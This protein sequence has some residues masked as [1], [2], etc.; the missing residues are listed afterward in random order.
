MIEDQEIRD[1]FQSDGLEQIQRIEAGILE[2]EQN[3][4][5][6]ELLKSIFR[7]AHSLKGSAGILGLKEI[8]SITHV[9][10]DFLGGMSKGYSDY[11]P[12]YADRICYALDQLRL[13]I[14]QA[15][16]GEPAGVELRK[17]VD[18]LQ[19]KLPIEGRAQ[20][21]AGAV[22]S[23]A[24]APTG[25]E[26]AAAAE[27]AAPEDAGAASAD[28]AGAIVPAVHRDAGAGEVSAAKPAAE[29]RKPAR[30]L[31]MMRVDP[32]RL[33]QLL[34]NTGELIIAKNRIQKR[35][36]EVAR[37]LLELEEFSKVWRRLSGF[38]PGDKQAWDAL[39]RQLASLKVKS[40][41]DAAKLDQVAG[42]LES[43]VHKVRLLP[44]SSA[45]DILPR[46][47]RD[48]SREL[49]KSVYLA[50][51][52]GDV[53]ADK[54][55]I[56]ELKDALMHLVRN[57][58]DHG[59]ETE[60]ERE[61]V[62]K[63]NPAR[64]RV[65]GVQSG[66]FIRI[67][68]EDDGRGLNAR[69]IREI[70][71][72]KQLFSE[73]ELEAMPDAQVFQIIFHNGF[74]TRREVTNLSG[75]GY[76]MDIVRNFADR[77]KGSI[78]IDSAPGAGTKFS[79]KIPTNFSTNQVL[80]AGSNG[81]KYGVPTE[82]V[83]QSLVVRKEAIRFVESRPV[84]Q[85]AG[86]PV[87][88]IR[89]ADFFPVHHVRTEAVKRNHRYETCIVLNYNGDRLALAADYI[90]EKQ[91]I[92]LKPLQGILLSVRKLSGTAILESGEICGVLNL[93]NLYQDVK[94]RAAAAHS[95][96]DDSANRRRERSVL[97]VEDS[98]I[99]RAQIQRIIE[100]EG[101][102]TL[103]ATNGEEAWEKL[104]NQPVSLVLTD[105][106]MPVLDGFEL[107]KR[108]R[109]SESFRELPTVLLTSLGS[110]EHIDKGKRLGAD[111]YL[112]KSQFDQNVLLQTVER[113]LAGA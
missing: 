22:A 82:F 57:S 12:E 76:G 69:S 59:I 37:L 18:V 20:P 70:A 47:V 48:I 113:L 107:L 81:W 97:V 84:I 105:V 19:G 10:E 74:S 36:G 112:V 42:K 46:M 26:K 99:T 94:G 91:E 85:F 7:E 53:T 33:D 43:G 106:E 5:D 65:A 45:F 72:S 50:I 3:P 75:R 68:V 51:E 52:G 1:L 58:L 41:Q 110:Q 108:I 11:S 98:L 31:E 90:Y 86:E 2:L 92:L 95:F 80:I 30:K 66:A 83:E 4:G 87:R 111:H 14:N 101:Y 109:A 21:R 60:E 56:E 63:A 54:L 40:Q 61:S 71:L 28:P 96:T 32:A 25:D 34:S 100:G 23:G 35:S 104:Q 24:R 89:M 38:D 102:A 78:D 15:V 29:A 9:L 67:E 27:S 62:G 16:T 103:T 73:Q 88:L 77:F 49:G 13:L 64:I 79:I 8:E 44:L 39:V 93:P 17:T 55:I 6:Q